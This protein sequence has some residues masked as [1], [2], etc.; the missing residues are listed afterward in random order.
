[1]KHGRHVPM[2]GEEQAAYAP[3]RIQS[4]IGQLR[5]TYLVCG[6]LYALFAILD[7][8]LV[9]RF[10]KAFLLIRFAIVVP[11]TVLYLVWTF[12][13]SFVRLAGILTPILNLAGGLGI[14]VM[15]VIYPANFSYYGG[16]FLVIFTSYFLAKQSTRSAVLVGVLT[17]LS[18]LLSYLLYHG[19]IGMEAVLALAFY[20]G[21]NVIGA[22]GNH[23]LEQ[24][25]RSHFLQQKEIARQNA[26]LQ[27]RVREQRAEIIQIEKA[28]DSTSDA[29]VICNAQGEITYCN[30]A[31]MQLVQPFFPDR[32]SPQRHPFE[33]VLD[34]VR[35]DQTYEE[36]RTLTAPMREPVVLL[37]QSDTVRDREGGLIGFV[38]TCRDI[39]ERK[40]TEEKM[41]FLSFHDNLTGLY[42]RAWFDEELRRLDRSRQL[43]LSLI[44]ADLNGLKLINDTYGHAM[45]DRFLQKSADIL[46]N[47]CRGDEIVARWGGDE[48]VVLLPK[49]SNAQAVMIA[50]R[51]VEACRN[52]SFAGIPISVALGVASKEDASEPVTVMLQSAEDRMYKQKL[53]ESRSHKSAVLLALRNTLQEK[54]FETDAHTSNM[55]AAAHYVGMRLGLSQDEMARL[56]LV[57]QLHDIGKINMPGELLRK[58]SPLTDEEWAVMRQHPEIG[59]RIAK[60]TDDVAHVAEEILSHHERWDGNGYPRKLKGTDIPLLARITTLV[61]AYEVMRNGRPY[62]APMSCAKIQ[63][64]IRS[65]AGKQFDPELA[66]IFLEWPEWQVCHD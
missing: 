46:R 15:L 5:R 51:I 26:L 27:E 29:V 58:N 32:T 43:P 37:T 61:D 2:T 48:F 50:E 45:G 22:I 21:A 64:E 34:L 39:T 31:Y 7:W 11:M 65:C 54:S 25:G 42:N 28:I 24:I 40:E 30:K 35:S 66:G 36:E 57:I 53:T 17:T 41:R 12:R 16:L 19:R 6:I 1:M 8:L 3:G 47:A 20:S 59:Y 56:D 10:L 38:T 13:P 52:T 14:A 9:D 63:S 60:V 55:Q 44:M 49:T 18:Y 62:K 23:Q 4:G 33:D